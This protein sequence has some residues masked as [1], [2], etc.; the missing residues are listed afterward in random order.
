MNPVT[1]AELLDMM[2]H[3]RL[4][5]YFALMTRGLDRDIE[6]IREV[7]LPNDTMMALFS[8]PN[9]VF[10][11]P[12]AHEIIATIVDD[13]DLWYAVEVSRMAERAPA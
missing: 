2:E 12:H 13:P 9:K 10:C 3:G 5:L 1:F 11:G 7:Y 8:I 4:E 6:L